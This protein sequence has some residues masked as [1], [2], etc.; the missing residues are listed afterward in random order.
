[1]KV[2]KRVFFCIILFFLLLITIQ[3]LHR[4]YYN[5]G[6]N[7]PTYNSELFLIFN[8]IICFFSVFSLLFNVQK[9]GVY[10]KINSLFY[11]ILRVGDFFLAISIAIFMLAM[12]NIDVSLSKILSE[13]ILTGITLSLCYLLFSDNLKYHKEQLEKEALVKEQFINEIGV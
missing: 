7:I 9:F 11:K 2:V 3:I 8:A 1:M 4:E 10:L 12:I 5:Y 6:L 13:V